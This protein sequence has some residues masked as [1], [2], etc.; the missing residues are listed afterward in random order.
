[1]KKLHLHFDRMIQGEFNLRAL[2]FL[3]VFQVNCP[4]CFLYGIPLVNKL[5]SEFNQDMS[6]L[7]ISTAFE[8]FEYNNEENTNLLISSGQMVGETK[9]AL[10]KEGFDVY[11]NKI[12]FPLAMDEMAS[13]SFDL[14]STAEK[15]CQLNPNYAIW[16][17]FEQSALLRRVKGYLNALEKIALTFTI[18]QFR[19]TP[20]MLV[21]NDA[22]EILF[23]QFGH[24]KYDVLKTNLKD[25]VDRFGKD[26]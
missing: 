19:G 26:H 7:G 6:F 17:D 21:F 22:Y 18:N 24:V 5:F 13:E 1:M 10:A 23:H 2:N 9:K 11:P 25:L 3:F 16:P 15:I 14:S 12:N 20:T 8:D 4:G